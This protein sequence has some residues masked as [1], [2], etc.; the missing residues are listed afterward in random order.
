MTAQIFAGLSPT[1]AFSFMRHRTVLAP[2]LV[3]ETVSKSFNVGI[4]DLS[5][6]SRK[7][8]LVEARMACIYLIRKYSPLTLKSIGKLFNRDH[9]TAIYNNS[10]C[11]NLMITNKDFRRHVEALEN[12]LI[13]GA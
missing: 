4:A 12:Q 13:K 2:E 6:A 11:E 7:R 8:S 9:T 5:S 1:T 3:I 10:A